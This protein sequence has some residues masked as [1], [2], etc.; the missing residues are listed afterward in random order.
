MKRTRK[1]TGRRYEDGIIA[2]EAALVLPILLLF[3]GLP[4]IVLA[5]Y[6]RQYSAAQKAANDAATYLSTAPRLEFTTATSGGDF[7]A[8]TVAKS[9]ITKELADVVPRGVNMDVNIGCLYWR[10]GNL[11]VNS[12]TPQNF[13]SDTFPLGEFNVAINLP[14]IS[15]VTGMEIESMYISTIPSVR[16]LGN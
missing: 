10:A 14:F 16:Y 4:S 6:F 2:V 7:A 12:C 11:K 9:I 13:K 3:L 1:S 15:P 5:F 8:L